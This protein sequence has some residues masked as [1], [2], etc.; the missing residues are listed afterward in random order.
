MADKPKPKGNAAAGKKPAAEKPVSRKEF[1]QLSEGVNELVGL[2]KQVLETPRGAAPAATPEESQREKD[3]TKAGPTKYTV[4]PEW[5]DIAREIV[6]EALDHTEVQY[7]KGGGMLFTLVIKNEFSNA[8]ADYLERYKS[9][10]RSKEVGAE[11]EAGVRLWCEQVRNNL[12]RP[13][14]NLASNE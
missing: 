11:G 5:E 4:N 3:I 13:K 1:N 12:K 7:I 10:R 6:G 14:L 9:D 2:V 8:P